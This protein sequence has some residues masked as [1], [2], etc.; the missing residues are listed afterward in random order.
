[1]QT[2]RELYDGSS[3]HFAC[4]PGNTPTQFAY[5]LDNMPMLY[6]NRTQSVP[7]INIDIQVTYQHLISKS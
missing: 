1:M 5:Q 4:R 7:Q 2:T 3:M 6:L